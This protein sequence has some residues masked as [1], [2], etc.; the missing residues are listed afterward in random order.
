MEKLAISDIRSQQVPSPSSFPP[1]LAFIPPTTPPPT[2]QRR[3]DFILAP[4]LFA[5]LVQEVAQSWMSDI[6]F[7]P[8]ALLVLQAA[9]EDYIVEIFEVRAIGF[10]RT[11]FNPCCVS[12][13]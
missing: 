13:R 7:E 8:D 6:P 2:L 3:T 12:H 4:E 10:A 11:R 9:S 1:P 5:R